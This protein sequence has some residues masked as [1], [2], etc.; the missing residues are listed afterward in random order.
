MTWN[1]FALFLDPFRKVHITSP[2]GSA[3]APKYYIRELFSDKLVIRKV[4]LD[5]N[6]ITKV[7]SEFMK[8]HPQK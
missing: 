6:N 8:T 2:N 4:R 3:I 1:P 5:G 7:N